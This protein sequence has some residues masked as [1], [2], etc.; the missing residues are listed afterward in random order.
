MSCGFRARSGSIGAAP[1]PPTLLRGRAGWATSPLLWRVGGV[2]TQ[3]IA[4]PCTPVRFRYSPPQSFKYLGRSRRLTKRGC[5]TPCRTF[6]F[7]F[8]SVLLSVGRVFTTVLVAPCS[9]WSRVTRVIACGTQLVSWQTG[10]TALLLGVIEIKK[11]SNHWYQ[12]QV[13]LAKKRAARRHRKKHRKVVPSHIAVQAPRVL[14]FSTNSTETIAFFDRLK[15][16]VFTRESYRRKG[17]VRT[18]N[19]RLHLDNIEHISLPCAVVLSAEL[20]RW[21]LHKGVVPELIDFKRWNRR[22]RSLLVHLGTLEHLGIPPRAYEREYDSTFPGQVVLV[23]LTSATTQDSEKVARLQRDIQALADFFEPQPYIFRALLEATNNSIE[24]AYEDGPPLKYSDNEGKRWYATAS[25]DP[26]KGS[27][28]FFVYDQGVGIPASLSSKSYW[29]EQVGTLLAKLG[30]SSH[31]TEMI[32]AAFELG[33]TRTQLPERGKGL[34]DM[35]NVI[36]AAGAGYF[37]VISGMGDFTTYADGRVEKHMH[38][39]HIGGTLVEWSIPV[40]AVS[41]EAQ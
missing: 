38:G 21:T 23:E 25:Y 39:S 4:N 26:N 32:G 12:Q 29:R 18:K 9:H 5:H 20:K 16:A 31:D 10:T 27:L 22:V 34:R 6:S 36:E 35:A 24:H 33:K 28:R 19:L 7:R 8:C 30:L 41:G 1:A 17:L 11:R 2:V 14:S 13:R 3:R 15:E 40:H 37:R